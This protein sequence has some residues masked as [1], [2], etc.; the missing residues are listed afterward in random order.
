MKCKRNNFVKFIIRHVYRFKLAISKRNLLPDRLKNLF[1]SLQPKVVKFGVA[2]LLLVVVVTAVIFTGAKPALVEEDDIYLEDVSGATSPKLNTGSTGQEVIKLQRA[3]G[4][5]GY[6]TAPL[7]GTYNGVTHLAVVNFQINNDLPPTGIV[8][9]ATLEFIFSE[10]AATAPECSTPEP[11]L[12]GSQGEQVLSLQ[13]TLVALGY[14]NRCTG[15]FSNETKNAIIKYQKD[16]NLAATGEANGT[17][18]ASLYQLTCSDTAEYPTLAEGESGD[19]VTKLQ[20]ALADLSLISADYIT[21][22]YGTITQRAISEFQAKMS[23][24]ATGTAD[25]ETQKFLYYAVQ[26]QGLDGSATPKYQPLK[27]KDQGSEVAKLQTALKKLGYF[28]NDVTDYYGTIT[29]EAVKN[30]QK[31]IGMSATGVADSRTQDKIYAHADK[32]PSS[33]KN[34]KTLTLKTESINVRRLQQG[35]KNL[36]YFSGEV[37]SYYGEKTASAVKA[38]QKAK[39]IAVTGVADIST[40]RLLFNL[41]PEAENIQVIEKLGWYDGG[42]KLFKKMDIATVIDVDTG[43][44][45]KVRRRGGSRH[46]DC[47]PLTAEDARIM[48]KIYGGKWSWNRRAIVVIVN[49]RYIAAS[50]NGM[51]HSPDFSKGDDFNG[52]FCIH[53]L[54]SEVHKTG[55]KCPIHQSCVEKA[56]KYGYKVLK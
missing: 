27:L 47:E 39:G 18:L 41:S 30:Y 10:E 5:K 6:Y 20:Q 46:A 56:Y 2:G 24:Q 42:S 51:P 32:M 52:H 31:Y 19:S 54:G 9:A 22:Y 17:T 33:G 14:L 29:E 28:N 55:K 36:G 12:F 35:L 8:D 50:M 21:G 7:T 23:L 45:F 13:R 1:S 37:T 40:Q 34:Y 43:L 49:G 3:L 15:K 26:A 25:S 48:K 11:I 16:N 44:S 38:F 53:F 4:E